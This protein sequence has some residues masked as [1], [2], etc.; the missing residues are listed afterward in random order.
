MDRHIS[1]HLEQPCWFS[2][3]VPA[4]NDQFF[5]GGGTLAAAT[6]AVPY[7]DCFDMEALELGKARLLHQ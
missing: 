3:F 4:K 7:F 1:F 5:S 2:T 6:N